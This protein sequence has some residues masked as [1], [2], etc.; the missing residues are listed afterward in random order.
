MGGK[1]G[2]DKYYLK[3]VEASS[4]ITKSPATAFRLAVLGLKEVAACYIPEGT[5][6]QDL[7]E[8]NAADSPIFPRP[9]KPE[10][11]S[12][13]DLGE[14][15]VLKGKVGKPI[16]IPLI[17]GDNADIFTGVVLDPSE[18]DFTIEESTYR[19]Y[20]IGKTEGEFF[21]ELQIQYN[22]CTICRLPVSVLVEASGAGEDPGLIDEGDIDDKDRDCEDIFD[23]GK[24]EYYE[25]L[26][27]FTWQKDPN[28]SMN[29]DH[30]IKVKYGQSATLQGQD[31]W[32]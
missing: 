4:P 20:L 9:D 31:F 29:V 15:E 6:A 26:D 11:T 27:T 32:T 14:G 17:L 16:E 2:K 5:V 8:S 28:S 10:C 23:E 21:I 19:I 7:G 13:L 25:E 1:T 3:L 24:K 18:E 22:G 12:E 30:N